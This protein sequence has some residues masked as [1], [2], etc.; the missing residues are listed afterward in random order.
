ME[1]LLTT[2]SITPLFRS[3]SQKRKSG[4]F[5]VRSSDGDTSSIHFHN[6]RIV[7]AA[8]MR[9]SEG[10][11]VCDRLVQLKHLRH[12]DALC[13][14][15]S[16]AGDLPALWKGLV[17]THGVPEKVLSDARRQYEMETLYR[18]RRLNGSPYRFRAE[19][20]GSDQTRVIDVAPGQ[21]LL[22]LVE[23]EEADAK[24]TEEFG[25]LEFSS[26]LLVRDRNVSENSLSIL[27]RRVCDVLSAK[28]SLREVYEQTLLTEIELRAALEALVSRG[29]ISVESTEENVAEDLLPEAE[30]EASPD[31]QDSWRSLIEN[32]S[33]M[34]SDLVE[35]P[36]V[37]APNTIASAQSAKS[38]QTTS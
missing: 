12:D 17:E 4:V 22:D 6:G 16:C 25:S 15:E 8:R 23:L 1:G 26:R 18:L 30:A 2:D 10:E 29:T 35:E 38:A 34:L 28:R 3:L 24:F 33:D 5:E 20:N 31:L 11:I 19:L 9:E 14:L 32:A 13:L 36:A 37:E 27:E 7:A 21:F